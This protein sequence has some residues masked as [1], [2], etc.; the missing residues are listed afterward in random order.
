MFNNRDSAW[1]AWLPGFLS[2]ELHRGDIVVIRSPEDPGLELVK[3]LIA[4]PGDT[5][6]FEE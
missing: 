4:L 6:K 2:P 5:L 1:L 3:R